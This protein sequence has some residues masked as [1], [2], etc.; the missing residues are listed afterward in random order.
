ME[1]LVFRTRKP[2]VQLTLSERG[3]IRRMLT[4]KCRVREIAD[5]LGKDRSTIFRELK[6]NRNAGNIYLENQAQSIVRKRRLSARTKCRIIENDVL[7]ERSVE[8]LLRFG[9][10]PDQIA[11]YM[12]RSRQHRAMSYRT[13]YRWV[14]R[15]WQSRKAL[16]RFHGKPRAPYG[17]RKNGWDPNKRHISARPAIVQKRERV[18]DWEADLVHGTQDDSRHCLLTLNDRATGFCIIR[19]LGA[20]DSRTVGYAITHA[21]KSLPVRTITCDNGSEFGRHRMIERRLKC[22]VYFTDSN[23]PQQRG[24]NENLNGLVR[25]FFPKGRSMR[26]VEQLHATEVAR[27]LNGRPRKRLEYQ[28]PRRVFAAKTG[29]SP[30]FVR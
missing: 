21:L 25:Q 10:S 8:K 1:T 15:E 13:V 2:F 9:L 12:R 11:G 4:R 14:H 3:I 17:S 6:R 5:V 27:R 7:L 16:L 29:K 23:S 24:S 18:G 22:K 26:H 30:L 28:A 20:L 19:K